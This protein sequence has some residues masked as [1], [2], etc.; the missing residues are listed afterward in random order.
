MIKA[1]VS[2]T[3]DPITVGHLDI[4]KRATSMFEEVHVVIFNNSE[5]STMFSSEQRKQM[6]ESACTEIKNIKIS[7]YSGLLAEY[8]KAENIS[9]IVR[10]IRSPIDTSYEFSLATIN[11]G[12]GNFPDTILLPS[13]PAF[14]HIS[15]SFVRDMIRYR[16]P[17]NGI[18]PDKTLNLLNH[19]L[20]N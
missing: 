5:K 16:Q 11:K 3:F 2:G 8:T 14:S 13:N 15:S 6:L 17:L 19:F 18:I 9:V 4:I 10:G 20:Q 12:L 1:L 7:V